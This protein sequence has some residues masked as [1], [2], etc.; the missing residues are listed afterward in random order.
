MTLTFDCA[1]QV[2]VDIDVVSLRAE[3]ALC[4]RDQ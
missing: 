2:T 3:G 4:G 1:G